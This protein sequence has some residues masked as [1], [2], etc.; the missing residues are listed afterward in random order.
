MNKAETLE[1][2]KQFTPDRC[3][4]DSICGCYVDHEKNKKLTFRKAF[5][6]IPDEEMYKYL[7]IF[8][9]TL[10]GTFGKNLISL[11]FPLEQEQPGG[12]QDFLLTL[13]N[14]RLEDD[15]LVDECYDKIIANYVNGENYY[16]ILV[17]AV[18]DIPGVTG[19]GLQMDDASENI[20]D[21]ILCSICPVKLSKAGLGYNDIDN[22]IEER[23]RDW[24]VEGPV[25]GFLFPAFIERNTDIHNMLY[26]TKKPED[27]QPEFIESM[28]GG[29]A[30][31]SSNMQKDMFDSVVQT[32]IGEE[33]DYD[34]MKNI[35]DNLNEMIEDHE[36]DPEPLELTKKDVKQLLAD[37][38]VPEER[39]D[40]FDE[41]YVKCAGEGDIP[42]LA[43]NIA[44]TKKFD[45][46]TPDVVIKVK[47]DRTD[48]VESR[49][50]DGRQC[51][52][53]AV[54]DHIEVNG[55]NVRTFMNK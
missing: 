1:I 29:V 22:T 39:L 9:H 24:I 43:T 55:I 49:I 47:P 48:L 33:A 6:S 45:I 4:I 12:T 18:Y 41:N 32:T 37:S 54:D 16:I 5:G 14:S 38:G 8:Q 31:L 27:L 53:I 35:H 44:N 2:K 13:R 28:F 20:Y 25:K 34:I 51:L 11:E 3:T 42:L 40:Y 26:F 36:G 30:P 46:E 15:E 10:S 23:H 7:D 19:D 52:V 21:Y 17:H 50:V